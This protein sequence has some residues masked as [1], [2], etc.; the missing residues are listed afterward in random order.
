MINKIDRVYLLGV[1]GIG[2][3]LAEPLC[4][5]LTYHKNGTLDITLIDGDAFE[6]NKKVAKDNISL[7]TSGNMT[8]MGNIT[9]Q[10]FNPEHEGLNKAQ[11]TCLRLSYMPHIKYVPE[12]INKQSFT[13]LLLEDNGLQYTNLVIS[14]VDN[15]ATRKEVIE[16]L[17]ELTNLNFIYIN[18]GNSLDT[19]HFS[20]WARLNNVYKFS[21]PLLRYANLANPSDVVP[22]RCSVQEAS[23]PQLISANAAA[24]NLVL[25][26]IQNI[27]DGLPVYE[28]VNTYVRLLKTK[29]LGTAQ[30]IITY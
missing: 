8:D 24:A 22:G 25:M 17:D 28:E 13:Q 10:L 6:L 29:P 5:L 19:A 7:E 30:T 20:I 27:L 12:Y 21:N 18:S 2:T 15:E 9:R 4:K 11:A 1:G 23:T 14:A 26:S 3:S 16:A